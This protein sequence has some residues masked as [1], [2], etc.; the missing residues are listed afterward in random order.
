MQRELRA[1]TVVMMLFVMA[2]S[3]ST[4]TTTTDAGATV[5]PANTATPSDLRARSAAVV[6]AWNQDDAAVVAD[7]YWTNA[8]VTAGDSVYSGMERIRTNWLSGLNMLSDLTVSEQTFS[9]SANDFVERGRYSYV[10]TEPGKSPQTISGTYETTWRKEGG[11]WLITAM[12][13]H[14]GA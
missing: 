2:C 1:A 9:G 8:V 7:F 14:D 13:V 11:T 5:T 3:S 4:S 10:L 12:K 6:S